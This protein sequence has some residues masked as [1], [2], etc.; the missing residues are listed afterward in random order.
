VTTA[1]ERPLKNSAA[2]SGIFKAAS[3][4]VTVAVH[5]AGKTAKTQTTALTPG[6]FNVEIKEELGLWTTVTNIYVDNPTR[7]ATV[8]LE[9][10]SRE[11]RLGEFLDEIYLLTKAGL[12]PRALD[13]VIDK[14]DRMLSKSEFQDCDE[15]LRRVDFSRMPSNVRRAFLMITYPAKDKLPAR[16]PAF[17]RALALLT[18]EKGAGTARQMLRTLE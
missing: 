9:M 2:P 13:T 7:S 3:A 5:P 10:Q 1:E 4:S 15:L 8:P 17:G 18:Q 16:A 14:V 12:V 11:Q 6:E